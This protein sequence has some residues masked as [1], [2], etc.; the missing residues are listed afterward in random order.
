VLRDLKAFYAYRGLIPA[1]Q[2]DKLKRQY[3]ADLARNKHNDCD[4]KG[5]IQLR[6]EA[7]FRKV[8]DRFKA[9]AAILPFADIRLTD[10]YSLSDADPREIDLALPRPVPQPAVKV[11]ED[12]AEGAVKKAEPGDDLE[13]RLARAR[14]DFALWKSRS[15]QS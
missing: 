9:L 4:Y 12:A 15:T 10:D 5:S 1:E 14:A 13:E 7:R 11:I 3:E 2:F 8:V 6:S